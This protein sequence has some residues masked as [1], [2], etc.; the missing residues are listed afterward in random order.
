MTETQRAAIEAAITALENDCDWNVRSDAVRGL[1]AAL[2]EQKDAEPVAWMYPDDCE[3]MKTSEA[4]CNVFSVP[5]SSPTQGTTTVPLYTHP[6]RREW[7]SLTDEERLDA[8]D[9]YC[10]ETSE[11]RWHYN[12]SYSYSEDEREAFDAG[13]EAAQAALKEK[14]A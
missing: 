11:G 6:P 13:W 2:A 12:E 7:V 4:W 5:C 8:F 14:N 3:R 10:A 9:A 1:R